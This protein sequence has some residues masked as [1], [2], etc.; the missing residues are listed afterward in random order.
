MERQNRNGESLSGT[1]YS[2][3][4]S[5]KLIH[6][7]V[8][9]RSVDVHRAKIVADDIGLKSPPPSSY[10]YFRIGKNVKRGSNERQ[11]ERIGVDSGTKY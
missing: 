7:G 8:F 1:V 10:W 2:M 3:S 5:G 4:V 6:T 9:Q 11:V